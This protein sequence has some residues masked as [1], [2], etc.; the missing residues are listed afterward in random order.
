MRRERNQQSQGANAPGLWFG[1]TDRSTFLLERSC[2]FGRC[3]HPERP[4]VFCWGSESRQSDDFPRSAQRLQQPYSGGVLQMREA[5]LSCPDQHMRGA[6]SGV[7]PNQAVMRW[8][9]NALIVELSQRWKRR[10]KDMSDGCGRQKL[11][12]Q[13]CGQD[14][15]VTHTGE[16]DKTGGAIDSGFFEPYNL[17]R[18]TAGNRPDRA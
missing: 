10:V 7:K 13:S 15:D 6:L 5:G 17:Q 4:P 18:H 11:L 1:S 12:K 14:A 16:G 8:L 2:I 9:E 3:G